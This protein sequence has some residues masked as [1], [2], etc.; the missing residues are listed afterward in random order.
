MSGTAYTYDPATDKPTLT[1][2]ATFF[3]GGSH[4]GVGGNLGGIVAATYGSPFNPNTPGGSGANAAGNSCAPCRSGGGVVRLK[5]G[6]WLDITDNPFGHGAPVLCWYAP[7]IHV[8]GNAWFHGPRMDRV[9]AGTD[10][11][12]RTTLSR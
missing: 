7:A 9:G 1:G 6:D 8:A 10:S 2:G 4:G 11:I 12:M 5:T 3:S